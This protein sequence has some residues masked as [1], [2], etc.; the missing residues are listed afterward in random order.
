MRSNVEDKLTAA[1]NGAPKKRS[2]SN[3]MYN[4][5]QVTCHIIRTKA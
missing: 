5:N 2:M 4:S 1:K 3:K